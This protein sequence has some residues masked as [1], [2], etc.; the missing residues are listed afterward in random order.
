MD[1]NRLMG[2]KNNRINAILSATGMNSR[3]LV[4][5]LEDFLYP[6]IFFARFT[7]KNPFEHGNYGL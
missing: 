2:K 4:K 7:I 1:R 3:K 6:F 5:W